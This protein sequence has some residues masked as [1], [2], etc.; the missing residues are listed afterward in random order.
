MEMQDFPLPSKGLTVFQILFVPVVW[1]AGRL[2][3]WNMPR[4]LRKLFKEWVQKQ[5]GK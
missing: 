5:Q 2:A 4:D 1:L 3:Y